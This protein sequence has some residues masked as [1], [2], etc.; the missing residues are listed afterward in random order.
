[1]VVMVIMKLMLMRGDDDV[2]DGDA[3]NGEY[4]GDTVSSGVLIMVMMSMVL[5]VIYTVC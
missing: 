2:G 3:S 5:V 1:M 4:Y